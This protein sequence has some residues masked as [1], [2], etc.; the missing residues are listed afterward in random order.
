MNGIK[1]ND[2]ID[3]LIIIMTGA[4]TDMITVIYL[5]GFAVHL[6]KN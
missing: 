6:P 2:N 3:D 1:N 4:S 5:H